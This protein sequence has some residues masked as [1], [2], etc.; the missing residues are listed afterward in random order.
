LIFWSFLIV[1]TGVLYSIF[2]GMFPIHLPLLS[3]QPL[4]IIVDFFM[5]VVLL[6][7]LYFAIRRGILKPGYLTITKDGWIV[8]TLISSGIICELLIEAMAWRA[9]PSAES[10]YAPV[11]RRLGNL[12]LPADASADLA[13]TL[14][15]V[16]WWLKI[17]IVMA[18]LIYLPTSKHFH[19]ITSFFNT[20]FL[21]YQSFQCSFQIILANGLP[22]LLGRPG[23]ERTPIGHEAGALGKSSR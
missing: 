16:F 7:C 4:A 15:T 21:F 18:F 20:F 22:R 5:V 13:Q 17:L 1:N 23:G 19:V 12:L 8:L 14:W 9:A 10:G 6:T 11:G 3:S 2:Y